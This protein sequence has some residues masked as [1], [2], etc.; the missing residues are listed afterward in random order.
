MKFT[1]ER[2]WIDVIGRIWMPNTTAAYRQYVTRHDIDN[3]KDDNEEITRES[4]EHWIYLHFGDFSSI[5]D[6]HA[7]IGEQEFDWQDE[8]SEFTFNSCMFSDED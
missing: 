3:M 7:V 4:L 6:F 2:N 1:V 5:Q 8:E